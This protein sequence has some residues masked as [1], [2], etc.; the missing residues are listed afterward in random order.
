[1]AE[2]DPKIKILHVDEIAHTAARGGFE[3]KTR[4]QFLVG[5]HGPF[6]EHFAAGETSADTIAERL[7]KKALML[8][9]TGALKD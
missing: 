4:Y 1:M 6:F 5:S 8:R 2:L 3:M 9:E 7:N